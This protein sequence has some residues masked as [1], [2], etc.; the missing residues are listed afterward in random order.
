MVELERGGDF[1]A[2]WP[3]QTK[4]IS[5][6]GAACALKCAHCGGHYLS[7]MTPLNTWTATSTFKATSCLISGGCDLEGKVRVQEHL[8][9][10]KALKGE[11]RYNFH[12][13]LLSEEEIKAIV[14][15]ADV[16]SFDFVG[17]DS[18][19]KNTLKL[20]KTVEDYITCYGFLRKHCRKV[21]PH[22]CLGLEGGKFVGERRALQ[23]LAAAGAA[24]VVLIVFVP[25]RGTEYA[26]CQPPALTEIADFFKEARELLPA[27]Q[28]ILGCMRP[29]G[30]YRQDLDVAAVEL[31][32]DGIVQPTP[33]ALARAKELGRNIIKSQECCVL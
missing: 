12:V 3:V 17:A 15:L 8:I 19:I 27:A 2:A 33:Q 18:T 13:G 5:V 1:L 32:L 6:T 21:A 9:Q 7:G 30:R 31:G 14:P 26:R 16:V 22:I 28:L 20:D 25:T 23:L 24:Q 11:R 29:G 4:S 10:L